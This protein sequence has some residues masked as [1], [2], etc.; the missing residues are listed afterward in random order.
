[1]NH[2]ARQFIRAVGESALVSI[3]GPLRLSAYSEPQPDL[4]LLRPRSDEYASEPPTASDAFLLME[5]SDAT[6]SFDREVKAKLYAEHGVAELWIIDLAGRVLH[7]LREPREGRY[8]QLSMVRGGVL[9]VPTLGIAVDLTRL[10][11]SAS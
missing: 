9:P 10:F 6:L 7:L 2:L 8:A 11:A 5:V 4:A 1:V 3:Q